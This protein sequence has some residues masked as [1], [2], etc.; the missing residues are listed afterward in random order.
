M[1]FPMLSGEAFWLSAG[2]TGV[3]HA[4]EEPHR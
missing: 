3:M 2:R 1:R 4:W